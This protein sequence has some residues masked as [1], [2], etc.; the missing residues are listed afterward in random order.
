MD[1]NHEEKDILNEEERIPEVTEE[2]ASEVTEEVAPEV[3][4]ELV[5]QAGEV[6]AEEAVIAESIDAEESPEEENA[7]P[8]AVAP[9]PKKSSGAWKFIVGI[10]CGVVLTLMIAGLIVAGIFVGKWV[11]GLSFGDSQDIPEVGETMP[12]EIVS[13]TITDEE[14]AQ[15]ADEV[16]AVVGDSYLTNGMLQLFY[17]AEV[18]NFLNQ[19]GYYISMFGLDP[20]AP[21][22]EQP[23]YSDPNMSWQ[24][25]FMENAIHN[26]KSYAVLL[27]M[28][29]EEGYTLTAEAQEKVDNVE[30][31]LKEDATAAG[32]ASLEEMIKE[33]AGA[34]ASVEAFIAYQTLLYQSLDYFDA[35][36][37]GMTPTADEIAAY[38]DENIAKYEESGITKGGIRVDVRHILTKVG[39][40][41]DENGQATSTDADWEACRVK[42][43]Q[44]LDQWKA[45]EATEESFGQLA[46]QVTED[47][48]SKASGG[49]YTDVVDGDM[50]TEFNDWIMDPA[51]K[52]GDTDLVKTQFGYHVMYFCDSEEIPTE[53]QNWYTTVQGEMLSSRFDAFYKIG[54]EKFPIRVFYSRIGLTAV[55][56]S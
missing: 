35:K 31:Q 52:P 10:A 5:P 27:E 41:T 56:L 28:S 17:R 45:G 1:A 2:V 43:Q 9:A 14:A 38:Y 39:T 20:A 11:S 34:G 40:T 8:T 22:D 48:G 15:K 19:Y 42:A 30:T 21:L 7:E 18:Y 50:V 36:Y 23:S 29:Q 49:L 26:W 6:L 55:P 12:A 25:L 53:E 13:Y 33:E 44:I 24:Q 16:I 54:E 3:T 51:R 47:D 32:Y 4:E 37:S 46:T